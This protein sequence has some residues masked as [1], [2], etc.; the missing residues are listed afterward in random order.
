MSNNLDNWA[1]TPLDVLVEYLRGHRGDVV[2]GILVDIV[3]SKMLPYDGEE[4]IKI[5]GRHLKH[6]PNRS[7]EESLEIAKMQVDKPIVECVTPNIL[8]YTYAAYVEH[9]KFRDDLSKRI[10]VCRKVHDWLNSGAIN[11]DDISVIKRRLNDLYGSL[12]VKNESLM[13]SAVSAVAVYD[14]MTALEVVPRGRDLFESFM[15]RL[16]YLASV[17]AVRNYRSPD[18]NGSEVFTYIFRQTNFKQVAVKK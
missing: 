12:H 15:K 11:P 3:S 5:C 10:T 7:R 6:L 1:P 2:E 13:D 16:N 18:T 14:V 4:I 8:V 17:Y 9:R